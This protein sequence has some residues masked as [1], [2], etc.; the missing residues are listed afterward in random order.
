MI[1][2]W[3]NPSCFFC[4]SSVLFPITERKNTPHPS[5]LMPRVVFR[6]QKMGAH[7]R[8]NAF[9]CKKWLWE[10]F[11]GEFPIPV[12]KKNSGCDYLL[13]RW[14]HNGG[15]FEAPP[16]EWKNVLKV[17]FWV[18]VYPWFSGEMCFVYSFLCLLQFTKKKKKK[19][20]RKSSSVCLWVMNVGAFI[21]F[22]AINIYVL[23]L[24]GQKYLSWKV[25]GRSIVQENY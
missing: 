17:L 8:G 7:H 14:F 13:C 9:L 24:F 11:L 10:W 22:L 1:L 18:E 21:L 12:K 20:L 23:R 3:G 16:L 5:N 15:C 2:V 19:I 4:A 25:V 6:E